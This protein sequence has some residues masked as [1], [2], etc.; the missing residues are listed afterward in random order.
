MEV[1]QIFQEVIMITAIPG[2]KVWVRQR[3]ARAASIWQDPPELQMLKFFVAD[4]SVLHFAI[5][6]SALTAG[7]VERITK[8]MPLSKDSMLVKPARKVTWIFIYKAITWV[9]CLPKRFEDVLTNP[10][11]NQAPNSQMIPLIEAHQVPA[12]NVFAGAMPCNLLVNVG[13]RKNNIL[14]NRPS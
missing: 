14:Q 1:D 7:K 9:C 3:L 4:K 5:F 13:S 11:V 6:T 2:L 8:E 10:A 12:R